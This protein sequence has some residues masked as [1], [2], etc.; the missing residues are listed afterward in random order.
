MVNPQ[1]DA[2]GNLKHLLTIEGQVQLAF[3]IL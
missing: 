3:G 2:E 1:L